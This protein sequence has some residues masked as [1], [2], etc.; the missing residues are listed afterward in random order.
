MAVSGHFGVHPRIAPCGA[1]CGAP[2]SDSRAVH[3]T[4]ARVAARPVHPAAVRVSTQLEVS[5]SAATHRERLLLVH[6]VDNKAEGTTSNE[7]G[8]EVN[9]TV[10]MFV[11][12]TPRGANA[13][14]TDRARRIAKKIVPTPF[15]A[16]PPSAVAST[17]DLASVP[18]HRS[19]QSTALSSAEASALSALAARQSRALQAELGMTAA[20]LREKN[21]Q[22]Q[23]AQQALRKRDGEITS[24]K[25]MLAQK[26]QQ[27]KAARA[28][29]VEARMQIQEKDVQLQTALEQLTTAAK[30]RAKL[31]EQLI[32]AQTELRETRT[33]LER[34]TVHLTELKNVMESVDL[35][36]LEEDASGELIIDNL[37]QA[38]NLEDDE[39]IEMLMDLNSLA[40]EL[41]KEA[42]QDEAIYEQLH[43][44]TEDARG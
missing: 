25:A 4:G 33:E 9:Q 7:D 35:D 28:E 39:Y 21:K 44:A 18:A 24:L 26:D 15:T 41:A 10:E 2:G 34:W 1:G 27:V 23:V 42:A 19:E 17:E 30:E 16:K 14:L 8:T 5:R 6:A 12:H 13:G 29:L 40:S 38:I 32:V 20:D 3:V 11:A 31:R 43:N 22:L 37:Q 36:V